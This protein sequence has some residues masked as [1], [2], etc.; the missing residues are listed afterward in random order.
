MKALKE[1]RISLRS[2]W[3]R[4]LVILSLFALVFASCSESGG[5]DSD[6]SGS[7][8]RVLSI[9]VVEDPVGAQ[10]LGTPVNLDGLVLHVKYGDG[11][12]PMEETIAYGKDTAKRFFAYPR[13]VTGAYVNSSLTTVAKVGSDGKTEV[14]NPIKTKA[15]GKDVPV[16]YSESGFVGMPEVIVYYDADGNYNTKWSAPIRIGDIKKPNG[17]RDQGHII[18]I[19]RGS[20]KDPVTGSSIWT[21]PQGTIYENYVWAQGLQMTGLV[22]ND[23]VY[24]DTK[25]FDFT[26]LDLWAD[27]EDGFRTKLSFENVSWNVLP[28]YNWKEKSGEGDDDY[29]YKGYV[30]VTVGEDVEGYLGKAI[31]ESRFITGSDYWYS[32]K[33][34]T[35][36][37]PLETVYTVYDKGNSIEVLGAT[38]KV[39]DFFFWELNTPEAWLAKLKNNNV[40]IRVK[41]RGNP[42][43]V[44]EFAI[45]DIANQDL[46]W[47]NFNPAVADRDFYVAPLKYPFTAKAN[48]KPK[49]R[50]YYR[51]GW[52]ELPIDVYTKLIEIRVPD[53]VTGG[54]LSWPANEKEEERDNDIWIDVQGTEKRLAEKIKVY[55]KYQTYLGDKTKDDVEL[56]WQEATREGGEL[57]GTRDGP[58]YITN[59][60]DI[61]PALAEGTK[62]K[63]KGLKITHRVE[64]ARLEATLI[65]KNTAA[66]EGRT[67]D[68]EKSYIYDITDIVADANYAGNAGTPGD[69]Y[70]LF[71]TDDLFA[72]E[73]NQNKKASINVE[74]T[75]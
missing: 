54:N 46:I 67:D 49:I 32:I 34:I 70:R 21:T 15:K 20:Q 5:G 50:V 33:G 28:D 69:D 3:R 18:G 48:P 56:K 36:A 24:A 65:A 72:K 2:L 47:A 40:S 23:K 38:E 63:T 26:G 43:D 61:Q 66:N 13:L 8:R 25:T 1:K 19:V 74:W 68:G 62:T 9:E 51:G 57:V 60:Q 37:A 12:L 29:Y 58:Y 31:S 73:T 42:P 6:G 35:A 7:G 30:Y 75:K 39:T 45:K 17:D 71:T 10:Y 11:Q 14:P 59:Y 53:P 16:L 4:G 52:G 55:A 27:Y 64:S 41:Y 44:N 22:R